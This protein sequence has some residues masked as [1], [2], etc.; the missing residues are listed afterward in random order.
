ML[1]RAQRCSEGGL[2]APSADVAQL[3]ANPNLTLSDQA[4][5]DLENGLTD[6]RVVQLLN[7]LVPNHRI[8]VSMI[9]TGHS[10]YV[11]GTDRV[12]NHYA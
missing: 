9:K 5:S 2:G 11:A 8:T 4:R 6:P 7:E 12:S 1:A 10:K 3:V